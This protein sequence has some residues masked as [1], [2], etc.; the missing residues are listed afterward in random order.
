MGA[1]L[2]ASLRAGAP[3]VLCLALA[4]CAA[5]GGA[6]TPDD[7]LP[8]FRDQRLSPEDAARAIV[9]GQTTR[10]G[11]AAALGPA[12][13]IHFDSGYEVWVYRARAATAD[14]GPGEF[15][16]LLAPSGVVTKIRIRWPPAIR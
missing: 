4:G 15:V 10:A 5:L 2:Q 11:L 9:I 3:A 1:R 14:A 12:K 8:S 7:R 6:D 13:T 16:V